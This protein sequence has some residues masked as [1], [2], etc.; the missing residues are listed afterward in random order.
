MKILKRTK[1][2]LR[3][4]T[5][6]GTIA[7]KDGVNELSDK[8]FK[9]IKAH[10]MY[11]A[12][13]KTS[14]LVLVAENTAKTPSQIKNEER[15]AKKAAKKAEE[16][17]K[18][19]AQAEKAKIEADSKAGEADSKAG[20]ADI[21]EDSNEDDS[22]KVSEDDSEKDSGEDGIDLSNIDLV[23]QDK[24]TLVEIAE[25]LEIETKGKNKEQIIELIEAK[26]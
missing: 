26:K 7:L 24:K 19:A 25:A 2:L 20:E 9:L 8:E 4:R 16:D 3:F 13:V 1:G 22:E 6:E 5:T 23:A 18:L 21:D 14:G 11:E 10:P 12:M 15:E 17:A